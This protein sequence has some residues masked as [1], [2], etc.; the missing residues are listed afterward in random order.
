MAVSPACRPL[1]APLR[2]GTR[3]VALKD[4]PLHELPHPLEILWL[5][6]VHDGA[7]VLLPA[8]QPVQDRQGVHD[9]VAGVGRLLELLH[10][11]VEAGEAGAGQLG[12]ASVNAVREVSEGGPPAVE[13]VEVLVEGDA[14]QVNGDAGE[15]A[16]GVGR[17][18]ELQQEPVVVGVTGVA[19]VR[20]DGSVFIYVWCRPMPPPIPLADP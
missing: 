10:P 5:E 2:P 7:R 12:Q 15:P 6:E 16:R 18:A 14:E 4:D 13:I 17:A 11:R 8:L 19:G 1:P 9:V 20:Y 3:A